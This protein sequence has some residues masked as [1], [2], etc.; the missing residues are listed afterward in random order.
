FHHALRVTT[1]NER[2]GYYEDFNGILHLAKSFHDGYVYDGIYSHHRK[3]TFGTR[4]NGFPGNK[5]IVFSQNHDQVGNRM[6]GERSS[7]LV[8]SDLQKVMAA[9]VILS[10]FLPFLFMGEEYAEKNPFQ[11]FVNHSDPDLVEAVR[12]GRKKEFATFHNGEEVPDPHSEETFTKSKLDWRHLTLPEH[13]N[14]FAYYQELIRWRKKIPA[15]FNPDR[16]AMEIKVYEAQRILLVYRWQIPH[17][18]LYVLNF[19]NEDQSVEIDP[20]DEPWVLA[21]HS[22]EN[23]RVNTSL[24]FYWQETNTIHSPAESFLL[25]IKPYV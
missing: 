4:T 13:Q 15:L 24:S 20:V 9:A 8:S 2:N 16:N 5:F 6:L 23:N 10:P 14:M 12:K 1:G 21:M 25:F 7:S 18:V 17:Q 22:L 19:S 11:Y 3:K